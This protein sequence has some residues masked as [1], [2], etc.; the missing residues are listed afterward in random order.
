MYDSWESRIHLFIKG[1]K[2]DRMMLDSTD[3]G[4]LVYPTV[5]ENG[6]TRPK[7]YSELTEAQKL[8]DDCDVQGTNIILHDLPPDLTL[9]LYTIYLSHHNIQVI[10]CIYLLRNRGIATTSKGNVIVGPPR[11][12][13]CYNYQG[14]GNMARQ[15]TQPKRPRNAAW[16]KEKLMLVEAQEVGQ[17]LDEEQLAFLA[18]PDCDDLS[19]AKAVLMAN[20]SSYDPQILSEELLVY[21]SQTCPNSPK[22]SEKLVVVTLINK[23]K[24]VRFTEP[25]T[26]LNNN[27]KQ[28]DSFK[29]KDSNKP[30]LTSTGVKPTTSASGSKP[31]GNTKNNMI[32]NALVKHSM[33]NA[34]FE[35]I[36]A[37]FNKCLFVD[38]HDMYLVDFVNDM[39]VPLK[40]KSNRN[41][42]IKAWKPTGCPDHPLVSGLRMFKTCDREPLSAHEL[43][44]IA[45]A[46]RAVEIADSPISTSIDQ[47]AP[48]SNSTFEGLSSNVRPS[49]NSFELIGRRTND[50]LIGNIIG[51][52]YR[53]IDA[54]QE[55]IY[56]FKR[57]QVWELVSCLDK[58]IL[59][60]LKWIYKVKT[61]EFGRV[62]KNKA[63][64]VSQGFRKE[65][66]IYFEESFASVARIDAIRIF[67]A[68]AANKN[69]T[70]FQMDIKTAFLKGELKKEVYVSQLKGFVDQEYPSHVYKLKKTL[71]GLKQAP[72]AWYD[73]L[74]SFLISQH[75]SK[76][77]I[78]PTLFTQ[79][80]RND[81]LLL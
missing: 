66:G 51:D 63:R 25:V 69:M 9:Q 28:I 48:S 37:I 20:L 32:T 68:N 53:S 21:A 62:L 35:Y 81:L 45:A 70:I 73:M 42:K 26:S 15:C 76:G 8:L 78:D 71:Y 10:Q 5:K 22:P 52:P 11:V 2:H 55:D 56:E 13:K 36:C 19:S 58:V 18:D 74:S 41:K 60:K 59:I 65:E 54:M 72:H 44:P 67:V 34:K 77:A 50:N 27:P 49:H 30:L 38:N 57:L 1:K 61:D 23:E 16:F 7:K 33:R 4:P 80:A 47:D 3:N 43:L 46:P 40:S 79:K 31:S 29:T 17:I 75:F 12:V 14:E 64:L 24:R 39:N 6:Q